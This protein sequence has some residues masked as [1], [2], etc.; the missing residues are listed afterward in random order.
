MQIILK[1]LS[2]NL[3]FHSNEARIPILNFCVYDLSLV[4]EVQGQRPNNLLKLVVCL[5]FKFESSRIS[6]SFESFLTWK[7]RFDGKLYRF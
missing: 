4:L 3:E 1:I 6:R 5:E 2:R 7:A